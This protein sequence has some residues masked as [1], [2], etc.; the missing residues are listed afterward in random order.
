MVVQSGLCGTCLD[1][2]KTG[3]LMSRLIQFQMVSFN[4]FC[5]LILVMVKKSLA[6]CDSDQKLRGA[7]SGADLFVDKGLVK[8]EGMGQ[9][10][11]A[12]S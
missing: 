11:R 9:S 2:D 1:I 6:D 3:L 8:V 7:Q 5:C 12:V 4:P 10:K